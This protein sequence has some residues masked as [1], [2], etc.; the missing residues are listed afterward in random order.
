MEIT[1]VIN[2]EPHVLK[3][4]PHNSLREIVHQVLK[5]SGNLGQPL[6]RWVLKDATGNE[7][8]LEKDAVALNLKVGDTLFLSLRAG[9]GGS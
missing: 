6:E 9:E 3:I 2:G 1:I 8:D 7:L 4:D 5:K